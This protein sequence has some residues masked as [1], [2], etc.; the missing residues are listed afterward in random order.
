MKAVIGQKLIASLKPKERP[1]EVRDSRLKGFLVRVQPSGAMTYVCQYGRGR[2]MVIGST[3][4]FKAEK[5]R[6]EATKIRGDAAKGLDPMAER[7]KR[8]SRTFEAFVKDVYVPLPPPYH[9]L[10]HSD[11][12]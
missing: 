12:R 4:V 6:G 2:R 8:K 1:Y 9:G 11:A 10:R 7:R 3:E 5:A